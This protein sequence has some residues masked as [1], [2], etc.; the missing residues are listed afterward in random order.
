MRSVSAVVGPRRIRRPRGPPKGR[1]WGGR[2]ETQGTARDWPPVKHCKCIARGNNCH[3]ELSNYFQNLSSNGERARMPAAPA[4]T[5]PFSPCSV[6][7]HR[8]PRPRSS[9][10]AP[11]R[12]GPPHPGPPFPLGRSPAQLPPASGLKAR[13]TPSSPSAP[14]LSLGFLVRMRP[15]GGPGPHRRVPEAGS[16]HHGSVPVHAQHGEAQRGWGGL[17]GRFR[18][19]RH[20]GKVTGPRGRGRARRGGSRGVP[21]EALR[22]RC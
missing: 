7:T 22:G 1:S 18:S 14:P 6:R 10:S 11:V 15:A 5:G 9:W 20:A 4:K 12:P 16:A 21:R 2:A 8:P 19:E 3:S 17:D 13:A